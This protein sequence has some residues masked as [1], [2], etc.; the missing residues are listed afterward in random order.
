M[1]HNAVE[2]ICRHVVGALL[3]STLHAGVASA[4]LIEFDVHFSSFT[5]SFNGVS[6]A[7]GPLTLSIQ[8]DTA[9]PNLVPGWGIYN[10]TFAVTAPALSLDHAVVTSPT[11]LYINVLPSIIGM[12]NT[13]SL[14]YNYLWTVSVGSLPIAHADDLSTLNVPF[15]PNPYS[16][17][18]LSTSN[19]GGAPIQLDNGSQ[20]DAGQFLVGGNDASV[21]AFVVPEPSVS[22]LLALGILLMRAR[23]NQ[24]VRHL[25]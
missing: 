15:G 8:T 24:A 1:R 10:A 19:L 13:P 17:Y 6:Q 12:L 11:Y 22:V 2:R 18:F 25:P 9:N 21:S 5:A 7:T 4:D 20:F 3:I 16:N 23:K 14:D